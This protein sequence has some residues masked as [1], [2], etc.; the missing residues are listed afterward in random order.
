[1][2]VEPEVAEMWRETVERCRVAA[3][4]DLREWEVLAFAIHHFW[5]T[6]D[7]AETRRQRREN[8]TLERDGWRCTAPGCR[9][10][11]TGRLQE[12]HVEFRSRG[13]TDA[14]W[15]RT[16]LCVGHSLGLIHEGKVRCSG[17]AP[18]AL[19]WEMGTAP[20]LRPFLV[21]AGESRIAGA[22]G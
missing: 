11:G 16:T 20:G 13:G 22:A 4:R 6:W 14:M 8:P 1:M 19:R 18:D 2:R 21:Y 9:S 5:E 3:E 10:V 7:N 12:H 17:E 15:N